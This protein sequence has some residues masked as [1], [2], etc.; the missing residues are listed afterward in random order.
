MNIGPSTSKWCKWD[1]VDVSI[2][3]FSRTHE[4][5][6]KKAIKNVAINSLT[7][8]LSITNDGLE[9]RVRY[10]KGHLAWKNGNMNLTWEPLSKS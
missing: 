4:L 1:G 10:L 3:E 6:S 8:N 9:V 2:P 5:F 7:K